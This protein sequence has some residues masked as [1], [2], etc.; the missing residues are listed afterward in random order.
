[1]NNMIMVLD[2]EFRRHVN[3]VVYS[4]IVI[5][6]QKHTII[7]GPHANNNGLQDNKQLVQNKY[8][9]MLLHVCGKQM[10]TICKRL[11]CVRNTVSIAAIYLWITES[12]VL[13]C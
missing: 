2:I 12:L 3:V 8:T 7:Y 9:P 1:M 11:C 5:K 10:A 4:V 6:L 13:K